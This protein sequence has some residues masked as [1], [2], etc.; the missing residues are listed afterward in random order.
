MTHEIPLV[1]SKY[2]TTTDMSTLTQGLSYNGH[3]VPQGFTTDFTTTY[4]FIRW[5][6]PRFGRA[7]VAA[8]I[9]DWQYVNPLFTSKSE[10]DENFRL[11]LIE[12]GYSKFMARLYWLGVTIGGG[13][14]FDDG[15][16]QRANPK[17]IK[18]EATRYSRTHGKVLDRKEAVA[19]ESVVGIVPGVTRPKE[20]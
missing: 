1:Y 5:F 3:T 15:T 10:A 20:D 6:I 8:T 14:S 17:V 9:H 4:W 2:N 13:A 7:N 16:K 18:R 11:N 19:V 12:I